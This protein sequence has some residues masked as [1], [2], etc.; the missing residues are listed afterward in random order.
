[1]VNRLPIPVRHAAVVRPGTLGAHNAPNLQQSWGNGRGSGQRR[2]TNHI[3]GMDVNTAIRQS[4]NDRT[5][6]LRCTSM[7]WCCDDTPTL[8]LQA[9]AWF[10][11][12]AR[13]RNK[14]RGRSH[15][16]SGSSPRTSD[17]DPHR[18]VRCRH[19]SKEGDGPV[20]Y[21]STEHV[22]HTRQITE[23]CFVVK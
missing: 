6:W 11:Q 10:R 5:K 2:V 7:R 16:Y 9:V 8:L 19:E 18:R 13:K 22:N 3:V 4:S 20:H 1:M 17:F 15:T 12:S 23:T 21:Y 14:R